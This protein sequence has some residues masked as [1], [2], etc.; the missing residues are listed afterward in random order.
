MYIGNIYIC[1][2]LAR[3]VEFPAW[4]PTV[5]AMLKRA[6]QLAQKKRQL[7]PELPKCSSSDFS[8]K[9]SPL[10]RQLAWNVGRGSAAGMMQKLA[11]AA[12]S[13]AGPRHVSK[14]PS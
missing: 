11:S 3:H 5:D 7:A 1:P 9:S 4:S 12:V 13:E 10:T 2:A 6:Q 8:L 14:S